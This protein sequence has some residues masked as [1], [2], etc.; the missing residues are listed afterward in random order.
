MRDP[1]HQ[2]TLRSLLDL[3]AKWECD[4]TLRYVAPIKVSS[5]P[6]YT[7]ADL[8]LGWHPTSSWE[9]SLL[10]ENLLHSR[11]PEFNAPGARR[12]LQ[13]AVYGKASWRF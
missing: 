1:N 9:F 11:H 4:A 10:G 13:R 12:E 2:V 8:R 6:G 5:V 7:E 3:S